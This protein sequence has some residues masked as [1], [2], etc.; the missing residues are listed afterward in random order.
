M[1]YTPRDL[2]I[3][4]ESNTVVMQTVQG[5]T[6]LPLYLSTGATSATGFS[7]RFNIGTGQSMIAATGS[8]IVVQPPLTIVNGL[9]GAF[10]LSASIDGMT[11]GVGGFFNQVAG[12]YVV[13]GISGS[14]MTV[15]VRNEGGLTFNAF[16]NNTYTNY[17][18]TLDVYRV[19]IHTTSQGG[20]LFTDRNT[21]TFV[22]DWSILGTDM[23]GIFFVN[24]AGTTTLADPSLS[25]SNPWAMEQ[26]HGNADGRW[27][28]PCEGCG[29]RGLS[30]GGT[31]LQRGNDHARALRRQ[32]LVLRLRYGRRC[33]RA[34]R[35]IGDLA[36]GDPRD[37]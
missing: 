2:Y 5:V 10:G 15:D 28:D 37:L 17:L 33:E 8:G 7:M 36:H 27:N 25:A 1:N 6:I 30:R 34:G 9:T 23:D 32:Q 29:I 4:A 35:G 3:G 13:R 24:D 14:T 18:N 31:R 22:G 19:T 11:S 26:R 21:R 16:L 20:A 12:A